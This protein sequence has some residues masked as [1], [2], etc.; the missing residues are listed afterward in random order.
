M[1]YNKYRCIQ[2]K[3]IRTQTHIA[4]LPETI[5]QTNPTKLI[6]K[7]FTWRGTDSEER[8]HGMIDCEQDSLCCNL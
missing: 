6:G 5:I 1:Y 8:G 7:G 3:D 4:I 2:F